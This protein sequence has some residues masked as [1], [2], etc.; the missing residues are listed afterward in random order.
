MPK[1]SRKPRNGKG[2]R[3]F[4]KT[5]TLG[6]GTLA[7]PANSAAAT[8]AGAPPPR[9]P[10]QAEGQAIR[11]PRV[12]RGRQREM[13]GFPLGGVAAGCLK[14]GG[15]GQ[16]E[17]WWIFNRPD[18]GRSPD[19]AFPAI[20]VETAG[21]KPIAKVLEARIM[22]PYSRG[23]SDL[24]SENVPGLPRLE[25]CTFTG[26]YPLARIDFEDAELPARVLL[27][28]FTPVFPLD[29]DES[30]LPLA[31]LRYRV[32]N[33]DATA[34]KVSIAWSI[35]NPVGQ[36]RDASGQANSG[37]GR[38]NDY[39]EG[40]GVKGLLM[41]NPF[42]GGSDPQAGTF[43]LSVLDADSGNLSYL[44][45]WP[46]SRWWD[47]P[48]FFWDDFTDDGRLGPPSGTP[49]PV[50]ALC[51]EKAIPARAS[52]EYTFLLTW[53]FPN[54]TPKRCGWS[55]PKGHE[56]DLIG[57]YYCTRFKDAWA[58]AEYTARNLPS[59]EERMHK[60]LE[61]VRNTTLPGAVK[62]AAMAN[63]STLAT[64]TAF[65]TSDGAFHGFEGCV[66]NSGCCFGSC[67]HVYAY[68]P[69]TAHI[70]PALSRSLRE[71]QF[72][73]S[74]DA[75]G[76]MDFRELLPFGIEHF[77]TAA[78]DGQM[79]CVVKAFLDWR[80]S[81][82]T[83]WLRRQWPGVKRALEFAWIKGGWDSNR[84]GVMEGVQ[85][86]TYDIEFIG[87][88]PFCGMWYLAALRAG[89][90]MAR[91][92]GDASTAAEYQRIFRQGSEWVDA[93][94]FN[95]EFYAQKVASIAKDDIAKGLQAGMGTVDT[96]HP[97]YQVGAGC[98]SDQLMGQYFALIAGL[99]LLV[100][101]ENVQKALRSIW[102]YNY[103]QNLDDH[104]SVQ[105][106]YALN[107]E[108]GLVICEYPH[109]E[110][111]R[112][113]FPYFAEVWSGSEYAAA[114]LMISMGM[115]AEGV[116]IVENTRRRFDGEK[117]NPWN[118]AECGYHY[119]RPMSSWAPLLALSGFRYDGIEKAVVARPLVEHEN[120][121]SFWSTGTAWG[122]F[123]QRTQSGKT[124]LDLS[125]AEG[126]LACR[127]LTMRAQKA[128]TSALTVKIR[129]KPLAYKV[130]QE[131]G[132]VTF[133]F[134]PDVTLSAGDQLVLTV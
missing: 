77:G 114:G 31:V 99:G 70:F 52:A 26:E 41:A 81:G 122:S 55:A 32:T 7:L 120:F 15:R 51:L 62:D 49:G 34:A 134:T 84:D 56:N 3:K 131:S 64:P 124:R 87:P 129:N 132:E 40:P 5:M 9:L 42:L 46:S 78:A 79:A 71:Q 33:P 119:A 35:E 4:L 58:V 126:N 86:N 13:I 18:K 128:A 44:R 65:R 50:G 127:K 89:E 73:Y 12:Y 39:R 121:S 8:G 76:L 17:E 125:V 1:S 110:R 91:A 61:A 48:L 95:G 2:R 29:A 85:H 19:Y 93:N 123:S 130:R 82:D 68:E 66:D 98:L 88:N 80:L 24:G 97:T 94:L 74:T 22:P 45:G 133:V 16:L 102:K 75:Q 90:E 6:V 21:R 107:N 27:E 36:E 43:A 53:H 109:G 83:D 111:P 96:E 113:P 103:K 23:P 37:H 14:L 63:L 115:V 112:V 60:F 57:N 47:S 30:G 101:R 59:L 54:R 25:T 11:Y 67:T 106:A 20:R 105:R 10:G 100:N 118:E 108:A 38:Q 117:R 116:Q 28:A 72:G 69:A 104:A 92:M